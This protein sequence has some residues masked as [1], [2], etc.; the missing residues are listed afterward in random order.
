MSRNTTKSNAPATEP[1][2]AERAD[3]TTDKLLL[4]VV[5]WGLAAVILAAPWFM[6]GRH[7]LGEFVLTLLAALVAVAWGVRRTLQRGDLSW[8]R[9]PAEFLLAA[10]VVLV[11]LQLVPLPQSILHVLSPAMA[12]LLPL[13]QPA[14]EMPLHLGTWSQVSMTPD[15]TVASLTMLMAYGLLLIV[16]VQR[17]RCIEDVEAILRCLAVSVTLLAAFGIVQYLTSNG[18]FLWIYQH[19]FRNTHDAVKGPFINK[20]HFAHLLAL[21]L[22]PLIWLVQGAI[23]RHHPSSAFGVTDRGAAR[24]PLAVLLPVVALGLVLFA[25]LMTL[26]RGGAAAML[27]AALV[28]AFALARAQLLEKKLLM[29]L[30]GSFLLIAVA[31]TIHGHQSLTARMGDFVSGS[32]DSLDRYGQR[33]QLW[34]ADARGCQDFLPLG[35]GVG[36]HRDVYPMYF[37]PSIDVELTHAES[38]PLQILLEAGVP[39]L[40][41]LVVGV[42]LCGSWCLSALR[43]PRSQRV[44]LCATALSASLAASLVHSLVD[45][46]WYIPSLMAITTLLAACALRLWQFGCASAQAVPKARVAVSRST[47]A[48]GTACVALAS[49]WMIGNRFCATMASPSWDRYLTY[50]LA[51]Q[52]S[53]GKA[54]LPG[55]TVFDDLQEVLRWTPGDARAHLRLAQI[56]LQQFE[57]QQASAANVMPLGQIRDAAMQSG[58]GSRAAL[59][60]WLSR[61]VGPS[62]HGLDRALWHTHRAVEQCP[63]L[64]EA[65]VYLGDLS[66]LEGAPA[67]AKQACIAQGLSVRPHS[68]EVLL[69]A[70]SD[71]VLTGNLDR[72]FAYWRGALEKDRAVQIALAELLA[73]YRIPVTLII[74]QFQPRLPV[75]RLL[76]AKY[77]AAGLPADELRPLLRYYTQVG[78]SEAAMLGDENAAGLWLEISNVYRSLNEPQEA[79]SCLRRA[80]A[81]NPNEYETHHALALYLLECRE[82]DE[83][84]NHLSWCMRRRP[85]D[86]HL[87]SMLADAV[88]QRVARSSST[89]NP[90]QAVER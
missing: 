13:W 55:P 72:A 90:V 54:P 27:V 23:S 2:R 43:R 12:R 1:L 56:C 71:A 70:G 37:E 67:T 25:G 10:V 24:S 9:S 51:R 69:A 65:Y 45:F 20:N 38:G 58:F 78:K 76:A 40:V 36:S 80:I 8:T 19:P 52:E 64:G 88:K 17:L 31:L 28:A 34:M 33:R 14:S 11:L 50:A 53:T 68:G 26:S 63:L 89:T 61:A 21:G 3:G 66:F 41:L 30:A 32:I 62:R 49:A 46:V 79:V 5:D 7:P 39:G 18:K 16:A 81:A 77:I 85:E 87:Q 57:Q 4:A 83:A 84:E 35:A 47:F 48:V 15:A 60:E 6:G 75:V 42:A 73:A 44:Y 59:D 22:G 86:K 29:G 74:E 82:F